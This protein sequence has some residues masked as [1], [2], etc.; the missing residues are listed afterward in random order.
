M[1]LPSLM[2]PYL[3]SGLLLPTKPQAAQQTP[4]RRLA[5]RDPNRSVSLRFTSRFYAPTGWLAFAFFS[6]INGGFIFRLIGFP[7]ISVS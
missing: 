6:F 5:T 1:P 2:R 7:T 3:R 4:A